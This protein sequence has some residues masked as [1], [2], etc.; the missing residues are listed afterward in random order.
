MV[1]K[2][3]QALSAKLEKLSAAMGVPLPP[4]PQ[5]PAE[6]P[7][8]LEWANPWLVEARRLDWL[9]GCLAE[10]NAALAAKQ[11]RKGKAGD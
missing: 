3:W 1:D 5:P 6:G 11:E 8:G 2:E 4:L 9:T 10:V 7:V